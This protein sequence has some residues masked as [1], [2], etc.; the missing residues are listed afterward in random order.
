MNAD[1]LAI[2]QAGSAT[3]S[4][5]PSPP[6][7]VVGGG[8]PDDISLPGASLSEPVVQ[9]GPSLVLIRDHKSICGGQYGARKNNCFCFS[10]LG[11]NKSCPGSHAAVKHPMVAK[12]C[13]ELPARIYFH[14]GPGK[15][16]AYAEPFVEVGDMDVFDLA[17]LVSRVFETWE[18]WRDEAVVLRAAA[19][20]KQDATLIKTAMKATKTLPRLKSFESRLAVTMD[21]GFGLELD[22]RLRVIGSAIDELLQES[23]MEVSELKIKANEE[24]AGGQEGRLDELMVLEHLN[25]V[26]KALAELHERAMGGLREL[27]VGFGVRLAGL[28]TVIGTF[29]SEESKAKQA[30][31]SVLRLVE[32]LEDQVNQLR[33]MD[34]VKS[35]IAKVFQSAEMNSQNESVKEAFRA[36]MHRL[37]SME[38]AVQDMQRRHNAHVVHNEGDRMDWLGQGSVGSDECGNSPHMNDPSQVQTVLKSMT[39]RIEGLEQAIIP[40]H[41]TEGEDVSVSFMGVRFTSEEDV[42]SYVES[43]CDGRFDVGPGLVTDCYALFHALNREIF[44]GKSKLGLV[45]LAKVGNLNMSQSDVYNILAAAEHGLPDFFDPPSSASKIYI[46]GKQGK[47]HRFSNIASYEV[48]GP[49]GT[50]KDA[51]RK[52]AETQLTRYVRTKRLELKL[53]SHPDLRAFLSHMLDV[54]KDFMEAIFA[55]LTEEYSALAE[56]FGDGSLCWDFACSCVEHVFKY[57]FEAARAVVN[58][59]DVADPLV[60]ARVMWQSLRTISVQESFMRVGFKN[61]SSLSSAYSRFL[62]TQYQQTAA[63]LA[64]MTKEVEN[65]KRSFGEM[66]GVVE[67]LEKRVKA[68]EGTANAAQNA[69]QRIKK[70][71]D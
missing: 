65:N 24:F 67:A 31:G 66:R 1:L 10:W 62:L 30:G 33:S 63:E 37:R 59:P 12:D 32:D 68:V 26:H 5:S 71:H 8:V 11:G 57:E 23:V 47:K 20:S 14:K 21:E 2:V 55:F 28:E 3:F 34:H 51:V 4:P 41:K 38:Q 46:D 58:N 60:K 70:H 17:N 50:I 36:V 52:R 54:S 7:L 29:S 61:H 13:E 18:A 40:G 9:M 64:K 27:Q 35:I 6:Q 45:D 19:G 44:D 16:A 25:L 48:W 43:L 69:V 39:T 15:N 22:Q 53:V 56:H 42:T 49:V